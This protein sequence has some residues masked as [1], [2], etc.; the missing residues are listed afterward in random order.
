MNED[1]NMWKWLAIG[2]ASIALVVFCCGIAGLGGLFWMGS[3]S[4]SEK[5]QITVS[6]PFEVGI[7]EDFLVTVSIKNISSQNITVD[8]IDISSNYL[9]GF[10]FDRVQPGF[11]ETYEYST[12]G[13]DNYQSYSFS[14]TIAPGETIDFVFTGRAVQSGDFSGELDTCID[15]PFNCQADVLRTIVK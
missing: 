13:D 12:L 4:P 11:I 9:Q 1:N 10:I 14:H 8:S 5:A 6:V 2:C 15:L 3:L 7:G